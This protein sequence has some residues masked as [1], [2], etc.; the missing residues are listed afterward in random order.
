MY[1]S[2]YQAP[3]VKEV[4]AITVNRQKTGAVLLPLFEETVVLSAQYSVQE[5]LFFLRT[6]VL[7]L[8]EPHND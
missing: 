1:A 8:K 3:L 4:H 7:R 2:I 5:N 6:Q